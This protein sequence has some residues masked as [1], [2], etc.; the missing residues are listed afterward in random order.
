MTVNSKTLSEGIVELLVFVR[1]AC[2]LKFTVQ[3]ECNEGTQSPVPL[4]L[5]LLLAQLLAFWSIQSHTMQTSCWHSY[6]HFGLYSHIQCKPPA[7]TATGILVYT[8]TY[9]AI[10]LISWIA[11]QDFN[12]CRLHCSHLVILNEL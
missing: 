8:V 5:L 12:T 7:G 6:W 1:W 4:L 3:H 11:L 10:H 9:N 2:S